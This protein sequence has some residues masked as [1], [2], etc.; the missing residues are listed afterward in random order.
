VTYTIE[1]KVFRVFDYL[2]GLNCPI[3]IIAQV[4]SC[5]PKNEFWNW[6]RAYIFP[7]SDAVQEGINNLVSGGADDNE[8]TQ[9]FDMEADDMIRLVPLKVTRDSSIAE[10]SA[11]NGLFVCDQDICAGPCGAA[12]ERCDTLYAVGDAVVGSADG[13]ASV[14]KMSN[15]AWVATAADPFGTSEN[16][17]T[18]ACFAIDRSTQRILVFRGS[19][20]AGAPAEAAYSDDNGATWTLANIGSDNGEFVSSPHAV[21]A[22]N[23]NNI[24]AGTDQGRIYFSSDGG[25]TWEI[26]EDQGIQAGGWNWIHMLDDRTGFAGGAGDSIAVTVDGGQVWSQVN[27]TGDGGDITA[28]GVVDTNSFWVGTDDGQIYYTTDGGVTWDERAVTGSGVGRVDSIQFLNNMI[29]YI[30]M[31]DGSAKSTLLSTRNGGY[32]WEVIP[33]ATN[34]GVNSMVACGNNLVWAAGEASGG[35]PVIYKLQPA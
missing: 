5:A 12:N 27:A 2:E 26:Q 9:T 13:T 24:W 1:S 32:T 6:D 23:Q 22:L 10:V 8:V 11:L 25:A 15:G 28:G 3:P 29:G 34:L 17:S 33:T 35:K 19:T 21:S 30:S 14:W 20:D 31:R 16:I 4:T 18:G 7:N